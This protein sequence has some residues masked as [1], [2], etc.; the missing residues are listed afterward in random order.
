[1]SKSFIKRATWRD[2]IRFDGRRL[3]L[4]RDEF[5]VVEDFVLGEG[6]PVEYRVRAGFGER[7]G[8]VVYSHEISAIIMERY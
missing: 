7:T 2:R 6:G 3:G 4:S 8:L 5:G 1:M